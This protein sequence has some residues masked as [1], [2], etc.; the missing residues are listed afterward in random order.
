[1]KNENFIIEVDGKVIECEM[2]LTFTKNNN[3]Y[4]VYIFILG[5]YNFRCNKL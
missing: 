4:I 2:F 5:T 3:S 1:M